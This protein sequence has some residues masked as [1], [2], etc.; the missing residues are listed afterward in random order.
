MIFMN[1]IKLVEN[2]NEKKQTYAILNKKNKV[3]L[4]NNEYETVI[5]LSYSMIEDRLLSFLHYLGVINRNDN[6]VYPSEYIDNIIRPLLKYKENVPKERIYKLNN[7]ST[8]IKIIKLFLKNNDD[9]I[10][11]IRDCY[12]II[13]KNIGTANMK[14]FLSDLRTWIKIRN[15]IVHAS[16]NKNINDLGANIEFSAREGYRLARLISSYTNKIK[17]NKM[18]VSVRDKWS[19]INEIS[20]YNISIDVQNKYDKYCLDNNQI[21]KSLYE[22]NVIQ[23]GKFIDLNMNYILNILTK[24]DKNKK[25]NIIINFIKKILECE[26]NAIYFLNYFI[27]K[28]EQ[29][30]KNEFIELHNIAPKILKNNFWLYL[31]YSKTF[32]KD[33]GVV[34]IDIYKYFGKI[35]IVKDIPEEYLKDL[36]GNKEFLIKWGEI[37][38]KNYIYF[39]FDN[40]YLYIEKEFYND[41]ELLLNLLNNNNLL[42]ANLV[43]LDLLLKID[44]KFNFHKM[45]R[46]VILENDYYK[47]LLDDSYEGYDLI[48]FLKKDGSILEY[49]SNKIKDT[50]KYVK[51]AMTSDSDAFI[52]SSKK[53]Q[54]DEELFQMYLENGCSFEIELEK[55]LL[56]FINNKKIA[57]SVLQ[58]TGIDFECFSSDIRN[59]EEYIEYKEKYESHFFDVEDEFDLPF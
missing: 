40:P 27:E 46:I 19:L 10:F 29:I 31:D 4:E 11:Y 55:Y 56:P 7:I 2:N 42:P 5:L 6:L 51:I 15:E 49:T 47:E 41:R 8:K 30:E 38:G 1:K 26:Y 12:S 18:Q 53:M 14:K 58:K 48:D 50:K 25:D 22:L 21:E 33:I 52:H 24:T 16:F 45:F 23:D 34:L 54:E 59:S 32:K 3:A 36:R 9:N 13:E 39:N 43:D 44:S 20:N 37:L 35:F 57:L 17:T 28:K